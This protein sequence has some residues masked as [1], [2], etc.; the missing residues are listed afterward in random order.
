MN[1]KKVSIVLFT[2]ICGFSQQIFSSN[3]IPVE[4]FFKSPTF[5]KPK[6]SP[7]GKYLAV[8]SPIMDKQNLVI[9]ETD[10]LTKIRAIT[11]ID[12]QDIHNFWWANNRDIVFDM[13]RR[14]DEAYAVYTVDIGESPKIKL[15]VGS[16]WGASGLKYARFAHS[17]PNDP[18]HILVH[19]NGRKITVSDLYKVPLNSNWSH[20]NR[21]NYQ[22]RLHAKNPGHAYRW[23]FDN[24]GDV[25]GALARVGA[26]IRFYYKEKSE[27]QFKVVQEY[28]MG[29]ESVHPLTFTADNKKMY[30]L[31]DKGRK[32][33]ALYL[34]DPLSPKHSELIVDNDNYDIVGVRTS[35]NG[36]EL[37]YAHYHAEYPQRVYLSNK[38]KMIAKS[39]GATFT[40]K[41]INYVT[42]S[43]D[44]SKEVLYVYSDID[45]G[46]YYLYDHINNSVKF[47]FSNRSWLKSEN[48]SPML[49]ISLT[50]RDGVKLNG[51]LTLPRDSKGKN[52]PLIINPHGGPY[53]VRDIWTFNLESQF[54][55]SRGYAVVQVNFR[56]SGGYGREF[57]RLGYDGKWGAEMQNDLTDTVKYLVDEGTADPKRV[58][59]YGAS[60]GGYAVLAGLAFT[61]DLYSCG[62]DYVGVSDIN[63]LFNSLPKHRKAEREIH[64]LRIGDPANSVLMKKMS[65]LEHADKIKVPLMIIQGARDPIVVK[66]HA[67]L[68]RDALEKNG[69]KLADDEWIMKRNE[70]HGFY[71]EENR[72]ELY[73]KIEKFLSK[74]L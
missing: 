27:T 59:I 53:G 67:L 25:R 38:R 11:G 21:K 68:M 34:L 47:L 32:T 3:I 45:P 72:I 52:L 7:D 56:G 73:S 9:M 26:N 39:L 6:L 65:P 74:H 62:I 1:L 70:G 23:V 46:S 13:D 55:A 54:F 51:Y 40:G 8:L 14:G 44:G 22:M 36:K 43:M 60:Y 63:L 57:E 2:F 20:K 37:R 18:D 17:L 48:M 58:C 42:E 69:K 35:R 29:Q 41:Q 15:L 66:K 12:D 49:P 30:F 16:S 5:T 10:D 71:G 61:P 50:S 24:D 4:L 64:K 33:K 31:S 28:R 19:Y